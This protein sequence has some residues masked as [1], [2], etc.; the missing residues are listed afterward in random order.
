MSIFNFEKKDTKEV[1]LTITT[2]TFV[3]TV[4]LIIATVIALMVL[5]Q[6]AHALFLIFIAVFLALSLNAPVHWLSSRMP[7]K[8]K[9]SRVAGTSISFLVVVVLLGAFLISVLPPIVKQT[10]NFI[11]NVPSLIDSARDTNTGLGQFVDKYNLQPKINQISSDLSSRLQSVGGAAFNTI[12]SVGNSVFA[13][14]TILTLT[15]MMLIE[16][17]HWGRFLRSLLPANRK[18]TVDRL[19]ADMYGVI[20]GFVNGQV[21]LAAIAGLMLLPGLL[22]LD[23]SYPIALVFVVFICGLIPLVGHY[24]GATIVTL[25]ALFQSPTTALFILLYYIL[26]QQIENYVI[27]PRV[28]ANSTNMSPLLVFMAVVVGVN[29]NGLVGGLVAIP[30][31]GCIRILILEYLTNK[32][33]ISDPV[34]NKEAKQII[35]DETK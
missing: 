19:A 11:S 14:L 30:L 26:Y 10:E 15:F 12:S 2:P 8:L 25:V 6:A 13:L 27:Q 24:M 3:K 20:K 21:T 5:R 35:R 18:E 32:N 17:P 33:M 29:F 9:G 22:I 7:G 16:G 28:Q 4:L 1:A 34:M 31:A 23:I